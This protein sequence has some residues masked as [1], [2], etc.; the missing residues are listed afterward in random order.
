MASK[1]ATIDIVNL[2]AGIIIISGGVLVM[3]NYINLGL[4]VTIIGIL[5]KAIEVVIKGGIK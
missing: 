4:L 2:I 1:K 3:L 5:F